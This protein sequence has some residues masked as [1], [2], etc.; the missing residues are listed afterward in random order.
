MKLLIVYMDA[1]VLS[2]SQNQVHYNVHALKLHFRNAMHS[3]KYLQN[4]LM[5]NLEQDPFLPTLLI[6]TRSRY[7]ATL[8]D[9]DCQ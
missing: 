2:H 1:F 7:T 6:F 8:H 4:I 9:I 5:I 3:Y